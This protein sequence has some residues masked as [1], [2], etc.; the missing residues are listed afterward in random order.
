MQIF[1]YLCGLK[2]QISDNILK[3]KKFSFIFVALALCGAGYAQHVTPLN[4]HLMDFSLDSLRIVYSADAPMYRA[5]L[6]R[7]QNVQDANEKAISQARRE[8]KDEKGHAKDITA[9]LK[10]RESVIT[11]LQKAYET[12]QKALSS[13]QSSIEKTQKKVQKTSLLNHQM[14]DAHITELQGDKKEMIRLQDELM[15]RQKRLTAMLDR[16]HTDQ[17]ALATF[18]ME[19]QNKEVDLTQ[20]E[21]TLKV[22]KNSVKAELKN[23]KASMK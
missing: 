2:K 16:L 12:E 5:E 18:N 11:S 9:Y 4:I 15:A 7:I 17:T 22:R 20:L 1:L 10:E 23:V 8:L 13:M 19:I 3:M 21:N 6:E 14:Q